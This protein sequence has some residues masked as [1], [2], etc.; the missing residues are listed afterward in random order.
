M[1]KNNTGTIIIAAVA[2]YF[3]LKKNDSGESPAQGALNYFGSGGGGLDLS[4]LGDMFSGLLG[5][6]QGGGGGLDLSGLFAGIGD[7]FSGLTGALGGGQGGGGGPDLSGLLG[8]SNGGG[9]LG[10]ALGGNGQIV[11]PSGGF[12]EP[13]ILAPSG[14]KV[15]D[16]GNVISQSSMSLAKAGLIGLGIYGGAKVGVPVLKA[17]APN[18]TRALSTPVSQIAGQAGRLGVSASRT[19]TSGLQAAG[20]LA[21]TAL[22]SPV[23]KLGIGGTAA[24]IPLVIGTGYGGYKLGELFNKTAVGKALIEKSGQAGTAFASTSLGQK[25]YGVAQ[26]APMSASTK[27]AFE[28]RWGITAEQAKTMS[29]AQL[30]AVMKGR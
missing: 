12:F 6:G 18:V 30:Q 5:G 19:A 8:G 26:I 23:T 1:R 25:V 22:K 15:T 20:R 29:T 17:I 9:L 10:G 13:T 11:Q 3:L 24:A 7:V 2:A 14:S 21:M 28:Q 16:I 27:S 4:G